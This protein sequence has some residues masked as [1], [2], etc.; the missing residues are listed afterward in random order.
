MFSRGDKGIKYTSTNQ[1]PGLGVYG[2]MCRVIA[3]IDKFK[4]LRTSRNYVVVNTMGGYEK[5]SHFDSY[6]GATTC[7]DLVLKH[8]IPKSR[9][10]ITAAK[11]LTIDDEYMAELERICERRM[12]KQQYHN[13]GY[14][15]R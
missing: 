9:Y 1:A 7:I 4:V 14:K 3:T 2:S 5:H 6:K 8:K 10:L 13:V 12:N 15:G 11:R